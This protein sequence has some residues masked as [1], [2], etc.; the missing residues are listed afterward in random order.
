MKSIKTKPNPHLKGKPAAPAQEFK[1]Y[2]ASAPV[3]DAVK[4]AW[5]YPASYGVALAS[6]G[7]LLLFAQ[8]DKNP[9][10]AVQRFYSED[11]AKAPLQQVELAGFS[12]SFELD[13]MEVLNALEGSGLPLLACERTREHPL[14]FAGG[15]VPT[16]NPEPYAP[17][18]DFFLI[19]EGEEALDELMLAY[20][21][22]RHIKDKTALLEALACEVA[23]LYAP[24]L[25][26][27][28]Y[29][30]PEGALSG[31]TPKLG[32]PFPV[33]KRKIDDLNSFVATSPIL[34]AASVFGHSYL[35]EVMRGCSHRCRFCLASYAT[36][37]ARGATLETLK[38]KISDGLAHTKKIGLLGALIADHPEFEELCHWLDTLEDVQI[39]FGAVRADT[40]TPAMCH[41]LAK[42]GSKSLTLAIESGSEP[43][44]RRI[45]KNLKQAAIYNAV[46]TVAQSGLKS[47]KLYGMVGL[48]DENE[49][50]LNATI[51]LLKDL[52]R[53]HPKL[54]ISLGCSTFVPKASTPFQ[55]MPRME[56]STLKHRQELL[57]K[58]LVKTAEFRPSSP[59]WDYVQA[60]L[61]RGDRRLLNF[62]LP[63][64]E[65]GGKPGSLNRTLKALKDSPIACPSPDWYALRERPET[66]VLPWEVLHLGQPKPLLYKESLAPNGW[67]PLS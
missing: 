2:E 32:V 28:E 46:E 49:A 6:L 65:F 60:L 7:Y 1:L 13:Y 62:L 45:N 39:S 25:Y 11:W 47:V 50:D 64:R 38:G 19:G 36:L 55:W 18:F 20:K 59:K 43:L 42:S 63:F 24:S 9:H 22:N 30:S 34:S 10:V 4:V 8:L 41:T 40:L 53:L 23:G 29:D 12:F 26:E 21:R 67:V 27:I 54:I 61:S 5:C 31:I 14:V 35:V 51:A 37:P 44:R 3:P 16:T 33:I 17:F 56:T 58:G 15:P 57:Q 66:E 48:P 52:K